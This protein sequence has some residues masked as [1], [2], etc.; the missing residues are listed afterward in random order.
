L[1]RALVGV[2]SSFTGISRNPEYAKAFLE[3]LLEGLATGH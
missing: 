1:V 3:K 2:L